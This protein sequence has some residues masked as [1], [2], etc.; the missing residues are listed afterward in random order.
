MK[1]IKYTMALLV[2]TLMLSFTAMAQEG[3]EDVV[4][5]K[6]GNIYRGLIIEQI[7]AVSM[8]I[9]TI[10]GN[11][12]TVAIVDIAKITKE[13]KIAP[14]P[15]AAPPAPAPYN[16]EPYHRGYGFNPFGHMGHGRYGCG[17][18]SGMCHHADFHYRNRGYFF[19]GQILFQYV[20]GGGRIINGYKFGSK[21]YLGVGIGVDMVYRSINRGRD[22]SGTY[23]PLFLYYSGDFFKRRV[24]PFYALEAGYALGYNSKDG[25]DNFSGDW[26][27]KRGGLMGG[28]GLGVRFFNPRNRA[29]LSV[30]LNMDAKNIRYKE[31]Y[32]TYDPAGNL[33][34]ASRMTSALLLLPGIKLAFGF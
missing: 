4:Y 32:N 27:E 12:F 21:G 5:L 19:Q 11:V 24:T 9:Q 33:I 6:N 3:M 22:L 14:A 23:L 1:T 7:P 26:S 15:E 2:M 10:G 30:S 13:A 8:K 34:L 16:Q 28:V 31:Y 25:F 17:M 20:Q 18:D 29:N